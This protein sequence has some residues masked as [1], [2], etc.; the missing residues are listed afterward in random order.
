MLKDISNKS[1]LSGNYDMD[2]NFREKMK[3]DPVKEGFPSYFLSFM[4]YDYHRVARK[5]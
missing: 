4:L 3:I 2:S 5:R 1:R